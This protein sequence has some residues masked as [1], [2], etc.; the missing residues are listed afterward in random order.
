MLNQMIHSA[1]KMF[2]SKKRM[3]ER[4]REKETKM[5]GREREVEGGGREREREGGME[6]KEGERKR[7]HPLLCFGIVFF[8]YRN[9]HL[10]L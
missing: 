4:D 1:T 3:R 10:S 2:L 6:R 5:G 8:R 9:T 7:E